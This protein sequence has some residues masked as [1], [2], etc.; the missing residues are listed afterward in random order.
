VVIDAVKAD[1]V[2][3]RLRRGGRSGAVSVREVGGGDALVGCAKPV[4]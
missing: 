1:V 2:A 4:V 3:E